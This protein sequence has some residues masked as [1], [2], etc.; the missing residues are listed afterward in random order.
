MDHSPSAGQ[1]VEVGSKLLKILGVSFGL[2]VIIGNTV[3]A[4]ILRTPG[5]IAQW[6]PG[7]WWFL[8]VWLAGGVYAL[9][10]AVSLAELGTAIPQSGGQYVFARRA[11]GDYTGFVVGWSDWLSTCGTTAA[12]S[13]IIGEYMVSLFPQLAG[14]SLRIA[15]VVTL[16]FALLQWHGVLWGA[17]V[18]NVTSFL[19]GLLFLLFVI[20]AF[21]LGGAHV[22]NSVSI[23][24]AVVAVPLAIGII[25]ALQAVIYTYDGWAG[26]V[27]FSEEVRDPS[28]DIP[29]SM[30][31]GVLL[32]IGLYILVNLSLVYVMPMTR[33]AGSDLAVGTAASE[34]FGAKGDTVI[35][36]IMI[37]SLASG[38]NAYHLMASRV[39]FAM[40]RDGLF[41]RSA[42]KVN[43]G[44]TPTISL[45]ISTAVAVAFILTGTFERV[46]SLLAFFFVANYTITFISVFV[47][48]SR[49]PELPRPYRAW[50]YPWTTVVVLLGSVAF[51]IAAIRD[52]RENSLSALLILLIS[53]PVFWIVKRSLRR[54]LE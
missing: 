11:L 3:G 38:I 43:S 6:L 8:A 54:S 15:L 28:R 14:Q 50:G 24:Q 12:V 27:Y 7:T 2:A 22:G 47:L 33:F 4:G 26:V 5:Q 42:S 53:G 21:S 48:R 40:S 19:K 18:Q 31:G 35:R 37:V 25:R 45:L 34:I 29:R 17:R 44:G 49:E 52:D 51:L 41:L 20:A 32:V 30:F 46:L 10:G 1:P 13:I 23:P 16:G 36:V 39:L 9:L